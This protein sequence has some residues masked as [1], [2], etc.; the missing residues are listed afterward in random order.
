M[1]R[2]ISARRRGPLRVTFMHDVE[3]RAG[4][5]DVQRAAEAIELD[6]SACATTGAPIVGGTTKGFAV[7]T[8]AHGSVEVRVGATA[9]SVGEDSRKGRLLPPE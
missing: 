5:R 4:H 3:I 6:P 1:T 8:K 9:A 2:P 7:A